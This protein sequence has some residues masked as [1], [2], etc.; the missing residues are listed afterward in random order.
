MDRPAVPAL[1]VFS[2][3]D[4]TLLD[5][6]T[7]SFDPARKALDAL[8]RQG[9]PLVLASSKTAVEIA[10]LRRK[11]GV[12]DFPAIV[13]NGAGVLP[14]GPLVS[15]KNEDYGRLR[16]ELFGLSADLRS[17]FEGFGDWNTAEIVRRTGLSEKEAEGAR[18]RQ[19]SEPGIWSGDDDGLN[20][21]RTALADRGITARHGGRFLTLSFGGSKADRMEEILQ[22]IACNTA[23]RPLTLA[24]GDAPNDTEMLEAADFGVVI[25]NPS[26]IALP[27]LDGELDGRIRRSILTGPAGW[28]DSILDILKEIGMPT[29]A[30]HR[31]ADFPVRADGS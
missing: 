9:L 11:I 1:V 8:R 27:P 31:R 2:D 29:E 7:Y 13:E 24:L 17:S 20:A 30:E 25:A 21:F 28:N 22:G 16:K 12:E 6:K 10:A 5:H 23:T 19:F 4:G 18:Q 3:L 15:G 14:P 26:D